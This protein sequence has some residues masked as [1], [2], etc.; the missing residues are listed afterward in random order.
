[1]LITW[2][3]IHPPDVIIMGIDSGFRFTNT[4][5]VC[6][7]AIFHQINYPSAFACNKVYNIESLKATIKDIFSLFSAGF[8]FKTLF[9]GIA[10]AMLMCS[11][12]SVL[13]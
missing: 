11:M 10:I 7:K 13:S 4:L 2:R 5:G 8:L 9:P 12:V 6:P 3:N 1:M